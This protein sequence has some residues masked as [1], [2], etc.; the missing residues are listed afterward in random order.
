MNTGTRRLMLGLAALFVLS[1]SSARAGLI[2]TA[3]NGTGAV[4]STGNAFDVILTNTGPSAVSLGGFSFGLTTAN[5]NITFTQANV[6]TTTPYI[7]PGANSLF[8]PVI[9]TTPPPAGQTVIA[10]DL[11][12]S[13][14]SL[15]VGNSVG[16]GHVLFDVSAGAANG[17]F[18][19]TLTPFPTTSLSDP[20]GNDVPVTSLVNGSITITGGTNGGGGTG[21][22]EPSTLLM[23]TLSGP[24]VWL[25]R[26]RRRAT[27]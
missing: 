3:K 12:I 23:L 19:V 9:S 14:V 13:G 11:G 22:P 1:A 20:N 5:S 10:S 25:A 21:V 18:P 27:A 8:G 26:R 16:L 17:T 15:G 24:V 6:S 7:F 2:V 4:G